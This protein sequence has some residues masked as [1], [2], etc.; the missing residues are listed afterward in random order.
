MIHAF[1]MIKTSPEISDDTI[2]YDIKNAKGVLEVYKIFGRFDLIVKVEVGEFIDEL[3]D[4]VDVIRS[5]QGVNSTE[6]FIVGEA[7]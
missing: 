7:L 3:D 4:L 5:T 1:I 6:T 2:K